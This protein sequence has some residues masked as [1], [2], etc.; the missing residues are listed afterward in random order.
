MWTGV[1]VPHAVLC[2]VWTPA[3][4]YPSLETHRSGKFCA[5]FFCSVYFSAPV[6]P[7]HV[8]IASAIAPTMA[9][10]RK[11]PIEVKTIRP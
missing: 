6:L 1:I 4:L 2:V 11:Q 7:T 3:H 9:P 8:P 5:P 10:H